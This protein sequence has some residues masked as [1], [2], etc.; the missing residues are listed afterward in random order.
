MTDH[1]EAYFSVD[2]EAA[3]PVPPDYSL[4]SIGACRV[5]DLSR[6]FYL[7]VQPINDNA[8][9]KALE[10]TGFSMER[11]TIVGVPPEPAMRNFAEWIAGSLSANEKP[12]FVGMNAPFD[13]A[14]V[15]YYFL[16]FLGENPFGIGGLDIKALYMGATGCSW[17]DTRSSRMPYPLQDKDR[18]H[19]ALED[20]KHQ[21][22]LFLMARGLAKR[23]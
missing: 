21:A 22:G 12:V 17:T 15:N 23:N 5:D 9:P 14:F 6:E 10:V 8:D 20:A 2:I 18:A 4:L 19:N 1:R 13:W 16:H 11:Q 7:E 3:G